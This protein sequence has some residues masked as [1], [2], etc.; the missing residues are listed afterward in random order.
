MGSKYVVR[1]NVQTED[2]VAYINDNL[3]N[4]TFLSWSVEPIYHD[5]KLITFVF[6]VREEKEEKEKQD[7]DKD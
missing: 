4:M 1:N 2:I 3:N 7:S 6:V 5:E